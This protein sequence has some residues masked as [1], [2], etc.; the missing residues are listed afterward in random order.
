[1]RGWMIVRRVFEIEE[2]RRERKPSAA[3]V[4]GERA[5]LLRI[6]APVFRGMLVGVAASCIAEPMIRAR[7][8][9]MRYNQPEPRLMPCRIAR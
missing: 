2:S 3:R 1:M 4:R 6:A 5:T 9:M 7:Q 8:K